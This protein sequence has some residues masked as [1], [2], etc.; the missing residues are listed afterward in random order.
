[1]EQ[2][3]LGID[4]RAGLLLRRTRIRT[5]LAWIK[6]DEAHGGGDRSKERALLVEQLRAVEEEL[7]SCQDAI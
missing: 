1:M 6:G 2:Q 5:E 3:A 7:K 4:R